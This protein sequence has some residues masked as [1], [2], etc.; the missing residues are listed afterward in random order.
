MAR[1]P[2]RRPVAPLLKTTI[3]DFGGGLNVIDTELNL[4][5][6]YSPVFDNMI[7]YADGSA[8]PRYGYEMVVKLQT[9]TVLAGNTPASTAFATTNLA[10]TVIINWTGHPFSNPS[11]AHLTIT[12]AGAVG[13]IPASEL[14][15]THSVRYVDANHIAIV[16]RVKATSTTTLAW[17]GQPYVIDNH[18]LGGKVVEGRYY[19]GYLI[20]ISDIGEIVRIAGDNTIQRIWSA[21]IAF[22]L[23]GSPL[24]W[25][26]T[27]LVAFDYWSGQLIL[28]NGFDKQ[29]RIDFTKTNIID[30]AVDP[31]NSN[32]NAKIPAFD[33]CKSA[34]RY[35]CVHDTDPAN[36]SDVR[37]VV[38]ITAKNTSV[39]FS[40]APS[41]GDAVDIDIAKIV[42]T[43][44][45]IIT[46]LALIRQS[47]MVI[48]PTA[49]VLINLGSYIT[50]SGATAQVHEPT[51]IDVLPNFGTSGMR[52]VV[53]VGNDVFMLDYSGVPSARLSTLQNTVVPDRIS[54]LIEPLIS[55]HMGRLSNATIKRYAFGMFDPRNRSLHFYLPKYDPADIRTLALNPFSYN[56]VTAATNTLMMFIRSHQFEVGDYIDIAGATAFGTLSAEQLNARHKVVGILSA[57]IILVNFAG[58][59]PSSNYQTGGGSVVTCQPVNDETIGYLYHYVPSLKIN[60]WSRIKGVKLNAGCISAEGRAFFFTD[61]KVLR[62]GSIDEPVHGDFYGDYDVNWF[63]STAYTVGQRVRDTISGQVFKCLIANTSPGAGT[64]AADRETRY[65]NWENYLGEPITWAWELPWA[66]FG[67]R[68]DVKALKHIHFDTSGDA[69]FKVQGF[70]D[71]LYRQN[72]TGMLLPVREIQFTGGDSG[73]YGSGDQPFGGGRRT[74]EQLLWQFP[75]RFKLLKLRMTGSSTKA[76]R[77][78]AISFLYQRGGLTRG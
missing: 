40:D 28:S 27:D 16:T 17:V 15:R 43:V 76:I 46:G 8:S 19:N 61:N 11:S 78:N 22:A 34:F 9:G 24:P 69:Q 37:T 56:E 31:G 75:A 55:A 1:Q 53:E 2:R 39:V 4:T 30:Y 44:E 41:P 23:G 50:P 71:Y 38:R 48:M 52:S 26:R 72:T 68:Q 73:G 45:P 63:V 54:T 35:F 14:N 25:R 64:F 7:R 12:T 66:D 3:R 32:S 29:L 33:A 59:A 18:A 42:S 49:S 74:R 51:P 21:S 47:L 62:Y 36:T 60:S 13:G 70:V 20:V 5:N 67:V 77:I 10:E 65:Q 58:T 57:D 6:R